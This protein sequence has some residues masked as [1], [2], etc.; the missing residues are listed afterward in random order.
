M[1]YRVTVPEN[2]HAS[3]FSCWLQRTFIKRTKALAHHEIIFSIP[4]RHPVFDG[5]FPDH[6][7]VPGVMLIDE[8]IYAVEFTTEKSMTGCH[9]TMTKFYSPVSPGE[10]LTLRFD[11]R[12]DA[13]I[14]F[15][16]HA[17]NRKV[18]AG[19]LSPAPRT[20]PC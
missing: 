2:Y 13:S 5:H 11:T 4:A 3:C 19:S 15:E 9:I 17:G 10:M 20:S 12:G 6:P 1:R 18:A 7:I 8:V 14:T 16:I